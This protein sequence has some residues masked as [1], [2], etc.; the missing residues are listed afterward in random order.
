LRNKKNKFIPSYG[1]DGLIKVN[2]EIVGFKVN[3]PSGRGITVK[4]NKFSDEVSKA[5]SNLKDGSALTINEIQAKDEN[6]NIKPL[7]AFNIIIGD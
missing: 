1:E 4:G 2:F 5:I 3:L 7:D 6:G